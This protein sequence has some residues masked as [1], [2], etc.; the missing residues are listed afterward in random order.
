M[1]H[2]RFLAFDHKWR[3]N[4][5]QFNGKKEGKTAAKQLSGDDVL[6]K[7]LPLKPII[8]GKG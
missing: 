3:N 8:F 4:K 6:K 1:G 2:C 7:I 5:S